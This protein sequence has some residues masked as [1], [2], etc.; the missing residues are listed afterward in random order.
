MAAGILIR[1]GRF[2]IQHQHP[3]ADAAIFDAFRLGISGFARAGKGMGPLKLD[4]VS[5]DLLVLLQP[6]GQLWIAA[7][8]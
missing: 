4:E 1:A 5:I 2:V 8:A 6:L 3:A 7:I